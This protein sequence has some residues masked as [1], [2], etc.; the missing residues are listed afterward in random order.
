MNI[1]Y[2]FTLNH[3]CITGSVEID[4][5]GSSAANDIATSILSNL[6]HG[7]KEILGRVVIDKGI[8]D[9]LIL[10]GNSSEYL[11]PLML[12]VV[13]ILSTKSYGFLKKSY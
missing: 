4:N 8:K 11:K 7:D 13:N 5:I 1:K 3:N 6:T 2:F 10:S 12:E 9:N